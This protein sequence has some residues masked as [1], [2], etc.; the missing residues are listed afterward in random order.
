MLFGRPGGA[1]LSR[2]KAH[3]KVALHLQNLN[4][5]S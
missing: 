4:F 2:F 1:A 3:V 5:N